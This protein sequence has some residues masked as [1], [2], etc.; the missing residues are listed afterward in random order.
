MEGTRESMV[1][2]RNEVRAVLQQIMIYSS[3]HR[4]VTDRSC[5]STPH[6]YPH[7]CIRLSRT[8]LSTVFYFCRVSLNDMKGCPTSSTRED[9]SNPSRAEICAANSQSH[10]GG[11]AG[12]LSV[13]LPAKLQHH[14]GVSMTSKIWDN[15]QPCHPLGLA[16][17]L[18]VILRSPPIRILPPSFPHGRQ[19]DPHNT[20]GQPIISLYINTTCDFYHHHNLPISFPDDVER[21]AI[22]SCNGGC[23]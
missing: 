1:C 11:G 4:S 22:G 17:P 20:L 3:L 13:R 16:S 6:S 8:C 14:A 19:P 2:T 9:L 23:C 12:R 18:S 15:A 10:C 7:E 21:N 5:T